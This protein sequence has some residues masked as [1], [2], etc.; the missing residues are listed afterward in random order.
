MYAL[1]EE[2]NKVTSTNI[3]KDSA[4]KIIWS[5][6]FVGSCAKNKRHNLVKEFFLFPV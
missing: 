5:R 1:D 3:T 4:L 6:Y 2:D